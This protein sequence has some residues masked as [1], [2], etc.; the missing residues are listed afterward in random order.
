MVPEFEQAR[1]AVEREW[2]A[3]RRT[4]AKGAFYRGLRERYE[5][6]VEVPGVEAPGADPPSE[7][8]GTSP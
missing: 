2:S 7:D 3:E 5:V 4:E 1:E 8:A 6:I